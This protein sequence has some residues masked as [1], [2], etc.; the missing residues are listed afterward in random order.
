MNL[1]VGA[2][3]WS[4]ALRCDSPAG[5]PQVSLLQDALEGGEVVCA[6]G[7]VPQELLQGGQRQ[8]IESGSSVI[9]P[10]FLWP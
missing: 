4:V 10:T 9:S 8:V 3:V 7:L 6:T 2:S 1:S 5:A